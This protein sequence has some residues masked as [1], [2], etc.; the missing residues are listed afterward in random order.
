MGD[1]KKKRRK[2]EQAAQATDW[3]NRIINTVLTVLTE[4]IIEAIKQRFGW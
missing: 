2:L 4:L 1:K 3:R